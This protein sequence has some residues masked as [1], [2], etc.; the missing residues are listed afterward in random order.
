MSAP[1]QSAKLVLFAL[2]ANLG[3][4]LA[5]FTG[6]LISGSVSMLAE[7]IHSLVDSANQ[8]LLLVGGKRA[9]LAPTPTHPLGYG[10]ESFFWSFVVAILLFSLGGLFAIY[11]GVHKLSSPTEVATPLLP[12]GIL[13]ISLVLEGLSFWACFREARA[14]AGAQG[15]WRW[16][17]R[18]TSVELLVVLAEDTAAMFGLLTATVA[19]L[20][21]WLTGDPRWDAAGSIVVG[22]VLVVVALFLAIEIKSLIIG[23][24][25][26]T[27]FRPYLEKNIP[28]HIPGGQ[29]LRLVALQIG[30]E[31]VM[32]SYKL[33]PGLV[34]G[35]R[36]LI[37]GINS[38][39]RDVRAEFPEVRWQ[40][41]EPDFEA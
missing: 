25:P 31:E 40:F 16:L 8:V 7:A 39:E 22:A 1:G 2:L 27:D 20:A 19:V 17:R 23:E 18:T 13:G 26:A 5:K 14:R 3:I 37:E 11:E 21:A 4:A 33:S 41:V 34:Q 28:L 10:R 15:V 24:A 29:L 9:R 32:L 12:L 36:E 38:L 30:A 6:A 35:A